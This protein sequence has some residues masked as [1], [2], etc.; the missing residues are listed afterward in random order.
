MLLFT[1]ALF[2]QGSGGRFSLFGVSGIF[3]LMLPLPLNYDLVVIQALQGWTSQ[4]AGQ[5]LEVLGVWHLMRGNLLLLEDKTFFIEEAC[6]GVNSLF[7]LITA[8]SIFSVW[9]KRHAALGIILIFLTI[10]WALVTNIARICIVTLGWYLLHVDLAAGWKHEALGAILFAVACLLCW[11]TNSLLRFLVSPSAAAKWKEGLPLKTSTTTSESRSSKNDF[12]SVRQPAAIWVGG[13][14]LFAVSL[15]AINIVRSPYMAIYHNDQFVHDLGLK[16][17]QDTIQEQLQ[18]D[19][20]LT[21]YE[22][23]ERELMSSWGKHSRVWKL[24]GQ[25]WTS[26]FSVDYLWQH[27]HDLAWC[28]GGVGWKI[29]NETV[30]EVDPG[31]PFVTLELNRLSGEQALVV[32]SLLDTDGDMF[33]SPTRRTIGSEI[34]GRVRFEMNRFAKFKDGVV[35]IQMYI[36]NVQM[37]DPAVPGIL[38]EYRKLRDVIRQQVK[39]VA[40][41]N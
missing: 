19:I 33:F 11:S 14:L 1:T 20:Q 16:L 28:Y 39:V 8:A 12:A 31:W 10:P 24:S 2:L 17:Q 3:L 5:F 22:V 7:A 26:D 38:G 23:Q 32:Y 4:Q 37:D 41:G 18:D 25:S 36:P 13:F 35:Q 21:G 34:A 27:Q 6:A 30:S 29:A 15:T 9:T 40:E